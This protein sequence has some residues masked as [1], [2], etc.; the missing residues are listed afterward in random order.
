MGEVIKESIRLISIFDGRQVHRLQH[1]W[2]ALCLFFDLLLGLLVFRI[3][4]L[5]ILENGLS[6]IQIL[7][8][9]PLTAV[10]LL[11]FFTEEFNQLHLHLLV[12]PFQRHSLVD[13]FSDLARLVLDVLVLVNDLL[14]KIFDYRLN[15]VDVFNSL[16]S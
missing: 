6:I 4:V 2:I 13:C 9:L 15:S 1:P 11:V 14:L 7:I 3:L 8:L 10:S 12:D 5:Y 16:L